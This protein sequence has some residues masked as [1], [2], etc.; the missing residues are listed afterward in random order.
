VQ[1]H[2]FDSGQ[3]LPRFSST[4]SIFDLANDLLPLGDAVKLHQQ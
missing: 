4:T 3:F 1:A 2:W